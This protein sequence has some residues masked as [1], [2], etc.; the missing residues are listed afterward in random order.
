MY[1]QL[2]SHRASQDPIRS[3]A[4]YTCQHAKMLGQYRID[5]SVADSLPTRREHQIARQ[6]YLRFHDA[7][8]MISAYKFAFL[9]KQQPTADNLKHVND[10]QLHSQRRQ[11][12]QNRRN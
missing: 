7:D 4:R 2:T 5:E 8:E 11:V 6:T 12:L 9:W 3:Q 1:I 10:T